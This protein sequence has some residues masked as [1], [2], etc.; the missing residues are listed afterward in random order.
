MLNCSSVDVAMVL[1][2]CREVTGANQACDAAECTLSGARL[3]GQQPQGLKV[4]VDSW[5][6]QLGPYL[7]ASE[8][9]S[10]KLPDFQTSGLFQ[11]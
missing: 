6:E 3:G 7:H 1:S 8:L 2:R 9:S 10:I 4:R 5:R 11:G